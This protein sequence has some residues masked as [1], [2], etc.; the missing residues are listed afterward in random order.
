MANKTLIL[1]PVCDRNIDALY[2]FFEALDDKL[3]SVCVLSKDG[4]LVKR[5]GENGKTAQKI[6][7]W[8]EVKSLRML[9]IYFILF[10][11]SIPGIFLY[12]LSLKFKKGVDQIICF[13]N[14]DKIFLTP[15]AKIL[16]I[17]VVWLIFPNE[18]K[19]RSGSIIDF[20]TRLTSKAASVICVTEY[21]K[22]NLVANKYRSWAVDSIVPGIKDKNPRQENIFEKLALNDKK[23]RLRKFFTVGCVMDLDSKQ[24]IETILQAVKKTLS[25]V[26]NLQLI[27]IGDGKEKKV[28]NWLVKKMEISNLVWFVGEQS[29]LEKWFD[30]FDVYVV[31][32][33]QG[34]LFD[35][36]NVLNAMSHGLPVIA[37][38][39][40]VWREIFSQSGA[41]ILV[42]KFESDDLAREIISLKRREDIRKNTGKEA[43]ALV[44]NKF[45]VDRMVEQFVEI[46]NK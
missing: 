8:P 45:R 10:P 38:E 40:G 19:G 14:F 41:G 9:A 23:N 26:Q 2:D 4:R 28:L 7:Y 39:N 31:G 29:H 25:V 37:P 24:N 36:S 13:S 32:P 33:K 12:I 1:N 43:K 6:K 17:K 16:K 30:N 27:I 3:G 18:E 5:C 22:N 42:E 20:I 34:T 21:A 46:L 35:I 15:L 44:D 11:I